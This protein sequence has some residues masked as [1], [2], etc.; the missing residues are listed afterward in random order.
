LPGST[1]ADEA[2]GHR[3]AVTQE[4]AVLQRRHVGGDLAVAAVAAAA[5]GGKVAQHA[6]RLRARAANARRRV[7]QI[8]SLRRHQ[9]FLDKRAQGESARRER[10]AMNGE[11]IAIGRELQR[12]EAEGLGALDAVACQ[13]VAGRRDA[14]PAVGCESHD[15]RLATL[16]YQQGIGL[17]VVPEVAH[18]HP[19]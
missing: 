13:T 9:P 1:S 8:P 19:L 2:R 18:R 4:I 5:V 16:G 10:L 6:P 3:I 7:D 12:I 15:A 14:V 17:R 11:R